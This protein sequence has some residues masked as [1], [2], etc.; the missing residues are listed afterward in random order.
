MSNIPGGTEEL[1]P[2]KRSLLALEKMQ[3]KLNALERVQNEPIAIIG[4]SCRFPGGANSP[5]AY[6]ELLRNGVDAITEVPRDRWDLDQLYDADPDAPG[7]MNTR[8]GGFLTGLDGF[9]AQFFGIS[10]REA[11]SL[12]PQQ[13]LLLEVSWEALERA[14]QS[15]DKLFASQ[16]G[17]FA[18]ITTSDYALVGKSGTDTA[19]VDVYT[20]MGAGTNVAVGRLSYLMGFQGPNVPVD[21][22]CSASLIAVHLACES[23]RAGS[24]DLALAGGVN[25]MFS[26][27]LT[28]FFSKMRV[29]APD[30]RC[31]TFD[32]AADGYVRGEGCGMVVLKRLSDAQAAGD[33]ILALIRGSAIN[34]NGR[35]NG[36]TAPSR[37]AQEAVIRKALARSGVAATDVSYVEAHGTGT[38][39]GDPIEIQ[40][41]GTIFGE[42]RAKDRPLAV[43][44][45][46]T[47]IGHTEL[48]AGIAGLIKTVLALQ[49][50]EIPPHLHFREPSPYIPWSQLP[51][52]V[53]T[54]L[55]PW[56]D[57][58]G[59]RYAG[60]SSFGFSGA[61][62]HVILEEAP[63]RSTPAEEQQEADQSY[64]LPLSARSPAALRALAQ[65]YA[66]TLETSSASLA[67]ICAT[68][69]L[70]RAHH[71]HRLAVVGNSPQAMAEQL[72]AWA[73]GQPAPNIV[74]G[75]AP[76]RRPRLAFAFPGQGSQWR[77]MGRQL[78]QADPT[79]RSTIEA[80]A[81]ALAPHTDWSLLDQLE[82]RGPDRLDELGV[83]QPVLWAMQVALAAV[84]QERGLHPDV[85][86]G[87]SMGEVAAAT[88]A[89]M[90]PLAEAAR[91]IA[92][93]SRLLQQLVGRGVMALVELPVAEAT[94]LL[95]PWATEVAVA[96]C[97]SPRSCVLAG[98]PGPLAELLAQVSERG[99]FWRYVKVDVASHSPQVDPILPALA[100]ELGV[101]DTAV[102][103]IPLRSTVRC[104]RLRG[105]ELTTSYW[106]DNLRQPVQFWDAVAAEA[107]D[108][109]LV[110]LEVSPH[111]ILAPLVAQGLNEAKLTGS[112]LGTL[113]REQDELGA[114]ALSLAELYVAGVPLTWER[115][116]SPTAPPVDLPTYPWQRERFWPEPEKANQ[117]QRRNALRHN[118]AHPLLDEPLKIAGMAGVFVCDGTLDP[119]ENPYLREHA[120]HGTAVLPAAVYL[121]L[122]LAAVHSAQKQPQTARFALADVQFQRT[123]VIPSD[124]SPV[125]IQVTGRQE[126]DRNTLVQIFSRRSDDEEWQLH[127]SSRAALHEVA[128]ARMSDTLITAVQSRCEH[129][130]AGEA[131]YKAMRQNGVDY[132][133][134]L[135]TLAEVWLGNAEALAQVRL[136]SQQ[137][138]ASTA[139][140]LAPALFDACFQVAELALARTSQHKTVAIPVGVEHVQVYGKP[141][142]KTWCYATISTT[143]ANEPRAEVTLLDDDGQIIAQLQGMRFQTLAQTASF[144]DPRDWM[145]ELA[146][147]AADEAPRQPA[148]LAGTWLL[149]AGT[150]DVAAVLANKL[151]SAGRCI[152]VTQGESFGR[153]SDSYVVRPN[154]LDDLRHVLQDVRNSGES[155]AGVV[156]LWGLDC[157]VDDHSASETLLHEQSRLC[158][159][160]VHLTQ[161]LAQLEW[162]NWPRIWLVTQGA[163]T[164]AGQPGTA[165]A[166]ASLWGLGRVLAIE[167]RE[168]WGG[169]IDLD[170]QAGALEASDQLLACIAQT[171]PEDHH[172]FRQQQ[173]YVARLAPQRSETRATFAC[174]SNASYLISGGL[175]DLGLE[176][177]AWLVKRG[178][179]DL[180]LA[181]RTPLPDQAAW[182]TIDADS[183]AGR[184]IAAIRSLEQKGARVQVATID[185]ADEASVGRF[186]ELR[187][188]AGQPAIRGIVHTAGV[189]DDKLL[190]QLDQAS[191]AE[192]MRP[193]VAGAWTLHR[194]FADT[195]LDFFVLF[196]SMGAILGVPGQGNYAAA[197]SFLDGLAEY[198]SAR[199]LPA[200]SINWASWNGLGFARSAGA[201]RMFKHAPVK[202]LE[203]AQALEIME[204]SI[205]QGVAQTVVLPLDRAALHAASAAGTV[206]ALLRNLVPAGETPASTE[207]ASVR[208]E[209]AAAPAEQRLALLEDYLRAQLAAVLRTTPERIEMEQ[210]L[211]SLGLDSIMGVELRNRLEAGLGLTLS[212]TLVWNYPTISALAQY[213]ATKLGIL[214]EAREQQTAEQLAPK[215]TTALSKALTAVE[216]LSDEEALSSL[217]GYD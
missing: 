199:G 159:G 14:G 148:A 54:E 160:V 45:V 211:G 149:C 118:R 127:A 210:S 208:A 43:G 115:L 110:L 77:G 36:L 50:K 129:G 128:Q 124:Q 106:V 83:I 18:G 8:Y 165:L 44:S 189:I 120:L 100:T 130:M 40:A 72:R 52:Y 16:T 61:N 29:M 105:A 47:N 181:G 87:H 204:R 26:P 82:G 102:G 68:A 23:L 116:V 135:Q 192:V 201:Q 46:K 78:L 94:A 59:R 11:V 156:Y 63:A 41:L 80:C 158:V 161:A 103:Q 151:S 217:L 31:K 104:T 190:L 91:L 111:P 197:N 74:A 22:A 64:L 2:I 167:H 34:H 93:R 73:E 28:V 107:A 123:L 84:W 39:L 176:V 185:I 53:P 32:A 194:I 76:A 147:Q 141:G 186:L 109:P 92:R 155:L 25:L 19:Q 13:R 136:P 15:A 6:W 125:A 170:P 90:L 62:A 10:P 137:G 70:R 79:F 140:V 65:A 98:A 21:T 184:Q 145:Y 188:A 209:I 171:S 24:C 58:S 175:G 182:P 60:V 33:P 42:G 207:H 183:R 154:S 114:F 195:P 75:L 138:E 81:V 206:A 20:G 216:Q 71:P 191:L 146:W 66:T 203:V 57:V 172:A 174:D 180:V 139:Q 187:R 5:E 3:A 205:G 163:Q 86:I 162:A 152:T 9:D 85:V 119:E 131:L 113:R 37:S 144:A 48:A 38:A 101:M 12:D 112:A 88:V 214:E 198:R 166:Q 27:M 142:L 133:P 134:R 193:K 97:N 213:L 117:S 177:A 49:H 35:S 196:S 30:G 4:M 108:G 17:V 56:T 212:A 55:K 179:R 51:V 202:G 96:V 150:S 7:K 157:N 173:R 95:A 99:V 143:E 200:T 164:V 168:L 215:D 69:S 178:A 122:A 153:G 126:Q 67:A 89:G 1:S 121:E 169:L 132:G